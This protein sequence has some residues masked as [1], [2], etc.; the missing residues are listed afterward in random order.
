MLQELINHDERINKIYVIGEK[1][2]L[3]QKQSIPNIT[4]ESV[5]VSHFF[6]NSQK[7]ISEIQE[8]KNSLNFSAEPID[9][10]TTKIICKHV[11][12]EIN[13]SLYG[14]D[15]VRQ[16]ST[17]DYFLIDINYM[18]GY[19]NIINLVD[20]FKNHFISTYENKFGIKFV[21]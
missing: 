3:Q 18:P 15:I 4:K 21:I 20:L 14:I 19:K 9:E 5:V 12:K 2:I 10:M 6:F 8:L 17:G 7:A 11:S 13:V 16:S 1:I